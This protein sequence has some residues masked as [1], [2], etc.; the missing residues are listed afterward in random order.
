MISRECPKNLE[1]ELNEEMG[2]VERIAVEIESTQFAAGNLTIKGYRNRSNFYE[3]GVQ[4]IEIKEVK[5]KV[6][7]KFFGVRIGS[8]TVVHPQEHLIVEISKDTRTGQVYFQGGI[9]PKGD[10]RLDYIAGLCFRHVE[11]YA[12]NYK[13]IRYR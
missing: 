3:C 4:L 7:R 9:V 1:K 13:R 11:N 12:R 6:P 8:K 10:K 2:L 5:G